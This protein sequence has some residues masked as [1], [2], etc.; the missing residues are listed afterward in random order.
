MSKQHGQSMVIIVLAFTALIAMLGL[1]IDG[2]NAFLQ[3]RKMQ[4]VADAAAFAGGRALAMQLAAGSTDQSSI[5]NAVN[6]Y[7]LLNGGSTSNNGLLVNYLKQD[8]SSNGG[9][10]Y[11]SIPPNTTG[12]KVASSTGFQ[13]L[14]LGVLNEG[15]G[16]ASAYAVVQTGAPSGAANLFP[17]AIPTGTLTIPAPPGGCNFIAGSECQIWGINQGRDSASRQWTSF[18]TGCGG[19]G[20]N[21]LASILNGTASS[22]L[23][24]IGD[25]I[26]TSTGSVNSIGNS[27]SPW[28]NKVV[29]VPVFDCTSAELNCPNYDSQNTGSNL[30]Y[31][32]ISFAVFRF[33][34]FHFGGQ[35]NGGTQSCNQST[36]TYLC[37]AFES[38]SLSGQV[39]VTK[40]CSNGS[41]YNYGLCSYQ[42]QQ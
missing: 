1:A 10:S 14:F 38:L 11:G 2:G 39:D 36:S 18:F 31:H 33:D 27:L 16:A 24:S 26:C 22:G 8:G 15:V 21:Y 13:T 30:R 4:N 6:Q 29:T 40:T 32:V 12:I 3:R 7:V 42:L 17:L 37:G 23:V 28:V 20:A 25:S 19:G 41:T 35:N 34:G 5:Y 9:F